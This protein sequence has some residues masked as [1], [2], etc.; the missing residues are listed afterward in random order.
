[1]TRSEPLGPDEVAKEVERLRERAA[2]AL[3]RSRQVEA[4]AVVLFEAARRYRETRARIDDLLAP[5]EQEVAPP[6]P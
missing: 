5:A 1:M 2:K 3:E 6:D 4:E